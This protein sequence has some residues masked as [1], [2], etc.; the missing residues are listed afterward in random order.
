MQRHPVLA[1]LPALWALAAGQDVAAAG[2][3]GL[4]R[5]HEHQDWLV[6][7]D[8][9]RNC[10]A[11]GYAGS[12]GD[13]I[14]QAAL[15]LHRSAGPGQAPTLELRFARFADTDRPPAPGQPMHLR[16]GALRLQL[17]AVDPRTEILHVPAAQV[18][19]L[20]QAV[21]RAARL[22][23]QA[24]PLRWQVS[25]AGARAAL[26]KLDDLQGR[27]GTPGALV[28]RGPRPEATVPQPAWPTVQAATLPP[29]GEA[30]RRLEPA[31]RAALPGPDDD[32]PGFDPQQPLAGP[33]RL[34]TR[35]LLVVQACFRGAYQLGS[36]LWQVDDT[37]PHAARLLRPPR[38]KPEPG[39]GPDDGVVVIERLQVDTQLELH[40]AAKSRGIGDCWSSSTWVWTRH[41]LALLAADQ[42][43]CRAFEAGGIAFTLW[44]AERR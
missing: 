37:P 29:T 1:C 15:V 41:G 9:T 17:P 43:P 36:R 31:L 6:A 14:G 5:I 27:V 12:P 28:A 3:P 40:E 19:A 32:C 42:S 4:G 10:Q 44:R 30:E 22:E 2:T 33:W 7:C 24:G 21:Q 26:L 38:P 35:S 25:L 20:L 11:Q 39:H 13:G 8:N 16:A 23:L 34:D 18:P